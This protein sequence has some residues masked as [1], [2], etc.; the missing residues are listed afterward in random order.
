MGGPC[1]RDH[2]FSTVSRISRSAIRA[3]TVIGPR[4]L[5]ASDHPRGEQGCHAL[6]PN[7]LPPRGE[8]PPAA[9]RG[10]QLV[11]TEELR[12]TSRPTLRLRSALLL[13]MMVAGGCAR[14][15]ADDE[16]ARL[17]AEDAVIAAL[18]VDTKA[19]SGDTLW[20]EPELDAALSRAVEAD[21]AAWIAHWREELAGVPRGLREN[22]IAAQRRERRLSQ[23]PAIAGR[24][25]HF[26]STTR[27]YPSGAPRWVMRVSRVGFNSAGD[28][29]I[30]STSY[31]CGPICGRFSTVLLARTV[32]TWTIVATLFDAWS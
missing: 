31:T 32:D 11:S 3:R 21:Q 7:F 16:A 26:D 4:V 19:A 17:A 30:V 20:L 27:A 6:Q 15:T 29:A 5:F 1:K 23:L 25:I 8:D 24:A 2:N 13:V 10:C 12:V 14:V 18:L 22:Y 28:S 9:A